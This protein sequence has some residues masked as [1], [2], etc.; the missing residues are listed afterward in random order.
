[1]DDILLGTIILVLGAAVCFF[2]LWGW[3]IL[4]PIWGF[5]AGF[6]VGA[7]GVTAV[8]GD[9]FLSTVSGWIVGFFVG[10]LFAAAS[11]LFWYVGVLIATG[12]VG[13]LLGSG[14]M[15]LFG[16]DSDWILFLVSLGTAALFVYVAF[17]IALPMFIVIGSTG[18]T[19][20]AGMVTGA[21]LIFNRIDLESLGQGS[22]VAFIEESWFWAILALVIAGAGIVF[23]LV[24]ASR[25]SLPEER[26]SREAPGYST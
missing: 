14:M 25:V 24:T 18:F 1:M 12:S 22:A 10:I 5:V 23:Q 8:F 9:G 4:L 20:A 17:V 7:T 19:G 3:F 15:E 26:W 13:A 2:G 6:F 16:V 11:Y 21:M